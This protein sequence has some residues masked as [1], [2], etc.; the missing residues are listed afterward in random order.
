MNEDDLELVN[1][2]MGFRVYATSVLELIMGG[3]KTLGKYSLTGNPSLATG[4]NHHKKPLPT[5]VIHA[6]IGK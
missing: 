6:V 2:S 5:D 1:R 4:I 3:Y